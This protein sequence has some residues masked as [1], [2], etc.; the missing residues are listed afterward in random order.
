MRFVGRKEGGQN[1]VLLHGGG[2]G[3]MG[4]ELPAG[5]ED[6]MSHDKFCLSLPHHSTAGTH[7]P[8]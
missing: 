4:A 8:H 2:G 3:E 7:P 5:P 1:K 6:T